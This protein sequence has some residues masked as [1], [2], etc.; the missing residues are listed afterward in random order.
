M[1]APALLRKLIKFITCGSIAAD[2]IIVTQFL[3]TFATI[4][5]SVELTQNQAFK[6]LS[7]LFKTQ[8]KIISS[9]SKV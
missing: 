1:S 5:F 8:S 3:S 2:F 6:I 9:F 7:Q 4:K